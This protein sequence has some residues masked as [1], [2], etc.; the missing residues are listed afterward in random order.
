MYGVLGKFKYLGRIIQ[1]NWEINGDVTHR[2]DTDG[3]SG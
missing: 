3:S 1:S 2:I